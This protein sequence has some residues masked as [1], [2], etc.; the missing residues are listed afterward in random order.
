MLKEPVAGRVKTR[1]ARGVGAVAAAGFYRAAVRQLLARLGQDGR[2]R[3][4]LAITPDAARLTRALPQAG[5][6]IVQGHGDLGQRMQRLLDRLPPGPVIIIGSDVPMIRP[7][8]IAAAFAAL[9][10]ADAVIGP[11]P[12]GGYWLVGA[13]RRPRVPRAFTSVRWSA[14]ETLS[15]TLR[16]LDRRSVAL[17]PTMSDV[18]D[19]G[20]LARLGSARGRLVVPGGWLAE[21]AGEHGWHALG[22][23]G[24]RGYVASIH[25]NAAVLFANMEAND[26]PLA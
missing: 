6:R 20:D 1:L 3:L 9:G 17:V 11:S 26:G 21:A 13:R 19:A 12:D 22:Q 4:L 10:G 5:S 7:S 8:D 25:A 14:A 2:W 24:R 23:G 15:D 16:N 18:D